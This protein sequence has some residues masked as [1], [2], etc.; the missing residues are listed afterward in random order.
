MIDLSNFSGPINPQNISDCLDREDRW[1]VDLTWCIFVIRIL[2]K[3]LIV[4]F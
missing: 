1:T 2:G 3:V 4:L